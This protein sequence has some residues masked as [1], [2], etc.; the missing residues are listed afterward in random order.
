VLPA[1][2]A[3]PNEPKDNVK[4]NKN[5]RPTPTSYLKKPGNERVPSTSNIDNNEERTVSKPIKPAKT[6]TKPQQTAKPIQSATKL[7]A[8]PKKSSK[9][10]KNKQSNDW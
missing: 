8:N 1:V 6:D 3:T 10:S 2:K 4:T 5:V 9:F 7:Q